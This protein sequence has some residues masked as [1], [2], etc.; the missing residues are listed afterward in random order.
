MQAPSPALHPLHLLCAAMLLVSTY[1]APLLAQTH[2]PASRAV[3]NIQITA[4]EEAPA[5]A[6]AS[7]T[8][9]V[10]HP[11]TVDYGY[12]SEIGLSTNQLFALQRSAQSARPRHIDGEQASRSYQRYLKSF[13]TAIPE[14]FETGMNLKKQ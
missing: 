1:S 9:L 6:T 8:N 11:A 14:Q 7:T 13:E 10:P 12:R 4:Q 3:A 2:D 5:P